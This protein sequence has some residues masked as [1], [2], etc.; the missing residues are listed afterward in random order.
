MA[1]LILFFQE[2]GIIDKVDGF[3]ASTITKAM[4]QKA[5]SRSCVEVIV[6]YAHA[7]ATAALDLSNGTSLLVIFSVRSR[8]MGP[9]TRTDSLVRAISEYDHVWC[10]LGL[11]GR[12]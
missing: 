5:V 4:E 3:V 9:E 2:S 11:L 7:G 1:S 8:Y 12:P 6:V 10:I